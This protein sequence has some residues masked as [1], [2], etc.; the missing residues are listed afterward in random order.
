MFLHLKPNAFVQAGLNSCR[1]NAHHTPAAVAG[2]QK[3][4]AR[5][6]TVASAQQP[7][8]QQQ[9]QQTLRHEP[10]DVSKRSVL[11][12]I[13]GWIGASWL[14]QAGSAAQ[15]GTAGPL[16]DLAA[17]ADLLPAVLQLEKTPDQSKYDPAVS[18]VAVC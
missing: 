5:T 12:G 18:G 1:Q 4:K 11:L 13:A 3:C 17:A 15:A 9:Q 2:P 6:A 8:H 16:L 10:S 7:G 14:Q